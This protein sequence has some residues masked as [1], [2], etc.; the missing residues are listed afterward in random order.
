MTVPEPRDA[1]PL[2]WGILAPGGIAHKFADAVRDLTAGSVVAV[3]S[4]D[5]SRAADF[6]AG[7][8][9]PR[10][11]AGYEHLVADEE[12]EAVYVASPH[13]LHRD[14]ALLA[15]AAG[16]HVLVEK[17]LARNAFEVEEIF[18]AAQR[19]E[20]FAMEA[21]WSRHLPHLAWVRERI[22]GGAIGEVVTISADHGQAL[23]MSPEHRLKNPDRGG[24]L[25]HRGQ[26]RG[27]RRL[28][29]ARPR[30]AAQG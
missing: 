22:A 14:H 3:G 29:C 6:A 9:I 5:A 27:G 18:A 19:R 7:H 30:S 16:K 8:G 23:D 1:P 17:A 25:R 4:R 20:V 15:I 2:R 12:V 24:R 21:M 11:Y 10:S 26:Y 13:S 28:L